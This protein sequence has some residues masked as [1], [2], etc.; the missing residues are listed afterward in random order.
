MQGY[1]T[2]WIHVWILTLALPESR[3]SS[4]STIIGCVMHLQGGSLSLCFFFAA[5]TG[6]TGRS[7]IQSDKEARGVSQLQLQRQV[8]SPDRHL[9]SERRR[10]HARGQPGLRLW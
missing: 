4:D 7:C 6:S 8:Q 3:R 9:G 2:T 5:G 1:L 10:A